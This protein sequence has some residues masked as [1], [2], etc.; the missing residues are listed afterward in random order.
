MIYGTRFD[1]S[2]L[3][4][5]SQF[6]KTIELIHKHQ[7]KFLLFSGGGNDI[8]GAELEAFLN[9]ASSGLEPL[10][11]SHLDY[12]LNEV[13][14][15]IF[16]VLITEA[17]NAAPGIQIFLH[18]YGYTIPDGR[19]VARVADFNFIGPWLRPAFAKKRI[20]QLTKAREII[21]IMIDKFN[22]MLVAIALQYPNVHYIDLRPIIQ[23]EDWANELHL[24]VKGYAKVAQEFT[25]QVNEVFAP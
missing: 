2:Y 15:K 19:A 22:D 12:I 7:P 14:T 8:A 13:F 24:T 21:R 23:D 9:H 25:R 20:D 16:E 4:E 10:R 18:G 17:S 1:K 3:P 5:K 11:I 6:E